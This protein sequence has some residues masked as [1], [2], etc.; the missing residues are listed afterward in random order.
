MEFFQNFSNAYKHVH[1]SRNF[2]KTIPPS[3]EEWNEFIKKMETLN[4]K[5]KEYLYLSIVHYH[6]LT[7]KT[8]EEYPYG[9]KFKGKDLVVNYSNL[10]HILQH[11]LLSSL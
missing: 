2:A 6:Y 1:K 3:D 4:D 5:Q 7:M 9:I 10:P 11:I 8:V